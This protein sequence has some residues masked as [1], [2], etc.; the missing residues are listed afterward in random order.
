MRPVCSSRR[1]CASTRTAT[2]SP[3]CASIRAIGDAYHIL[4]DE[5]VDEAPFAVFCPDPEPHMVIGQ[6][7]A[8]QTMD[9]AVDQVQHRPQLLDSLAGSIHPR[10][11]V[12]EGQ[13]NLDDAL[14]TEQGAMI[15]ARN[16][17]AVNELDEAVRRP[18]GAAGHRL[19]R[20]DQGQADRPV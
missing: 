19:R 8:D 12:V 7:V 13:V 18:A 20:S 10:T 2:A 14:N 15:R 5:V 17:N 11:V 4:H 6:S 3:S 9:I 16:I 1:T